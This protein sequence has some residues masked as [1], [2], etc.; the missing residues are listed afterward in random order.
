[1]RRSG[2]CC[3]SGSTAIIRLSAILITNSSN[4]EIHRFHIGSVELSSRMAGPN[5]VKPS[6]LQV[7]TLLNELQHESQLPLLVGGDFERGLASRVSGTPEFPFPMAFGAIQ[8]PAGGADPDIPILK[9]AKA[10]YAK[11]Q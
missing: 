4:S 1:M 7:V 6:P 9:Q 5:L 2:N 3:R 10:E 8:D 11:L